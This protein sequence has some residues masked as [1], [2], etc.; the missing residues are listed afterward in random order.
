MPFDYDWGDDLEDLYDPP[1]ALRPYDDLTLASPSAGAPL[2][3]LPTAV[4]ALENNTYDPTEECRGYVLT[5]TTYFISVISRYRTAC[6]DYE[7]MVTTYDN[8]KATWEDTDMATHTAQVTQVWATWNATQK[9]AADRAAIG[10]RD[11]ESRSTSSGSTTTSSSFATMLY[12]G[13]AMTSKIILR[14]DRQAPTCAFDG[15]DGEGPKIDSGR[16]GAAPHTVQ[17]GAVACHRDHRV[18]HVCGGFYEQVEPLDRHAAAEEAD[19]EASGH[20]QAP[21][22]CTP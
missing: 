18:R 4:R 8:D 2:S 14:R 5:Y 19:N 17:L 3:P 1:P 13:A 7:H 16:C 21:P 22:G 20:V 11:T 9:A 6:N 15:I 10:L 12:T